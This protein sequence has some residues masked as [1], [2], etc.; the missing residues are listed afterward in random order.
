MNSLFRKPR[1]QV[2]SRRLW[3]S[4]SKGDF[5]KYNTCAKTVFKCPWVLTY[6][7]SQRSIF[8]SASFRLLPYFVYARSEGSDKTVYNLLGFIL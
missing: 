1:R 2:F 4:S 7:A 5:G 8:L 6:P 3:S